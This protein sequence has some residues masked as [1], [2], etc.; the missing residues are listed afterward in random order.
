MANFRTHLAV[1]AVV[2]CGAAGVL[3]GLGTV[4]HG[5][6]A[7]LALLG[8]FGGILPDVDSD[9][10]SA[11]SIV[12]NLVAGM[13]TFLVFLMTYWAYDYLVSL[14]ACLVTFVVI[15]YPVQWIFAKFT[16]HRGAFHSV[17]AASMMGLTFTVGANF[18]LEAD[19]IL[20]WYTGLFVCLGYLVHLLLDEIYSV[21]FSNARIKRSFGSAIKPIS[22]KYPIGSFLFIVIVGGLYYISPETDKFI[23]TIL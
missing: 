21:D 15:R 19:S 1:A 23:E 18:V 13:F 5:Q 16:I 6:A 14:I 4:N 10:S 3:A 17:L 20:S 22:L 2:S 8:V 9:K 12:F 7:L 11:I